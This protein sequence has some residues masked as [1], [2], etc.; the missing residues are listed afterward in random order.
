MQVKMNASNVKGVSGLSCK[1]SQIDVRSTEKRG[2]A[3]FNDTYK[4]HFRLDF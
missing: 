3:S 2:V 1:F 4:Q